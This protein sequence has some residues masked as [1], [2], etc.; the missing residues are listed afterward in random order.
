ME[1]DKE[2][3]SKNLTR[4]K[5]M[6]F[7]NDKVTI[8][9]PLYN[10][11]YTIEKCIN[12]IKQQSYQNLQVILVDDKSHDDSIQ[13]SLE[14]IANDERF[15]IIKQKHNKGVSAAR[16]RGLQ[17]GNGKF[18]FFLDAD[19]WLENDAIEHLVTLANQTDSDFVC[20]SHI[21]NFDSTEN[22]KEDG[23]PDIDSTFSHSELI[24][25]I[26]NHLKSPYKFTLLVHCWAKLYNLK[27]IKDNSIHFDEQLSQLE[28]V[29]FNYYY[30]AHCNHVSYKNEYIYHHR[31]DSNSHSLSTMTGKE[32][33]AMTN[34]LLAFSSIRSYLNLRDNDTQINIE[35]EV[36]HLFITTTIITLIRLCKSMIRSPSM[37]LYKNI[38][39]IS[40]SPEVIENLKFYSSGQ[41]ESRLIS[42]ALK[43]RTPFFV[44]ISGLI[45]AY[46]LLLTK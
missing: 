8:V 3:I 36:A 28:D 25:Y 26:K 2:V 41:G 33:N 44:L 15:I 46:T 13:K 45:R 34:N 7:H 32:A 12:S 29:N 22:K 39:L 20:A 21:Q 16:N 18:L 38:T 4:I 23:T 6:S 17:Y 9:V 40:K 31:I 19:D 43:T 1:L 14:I 11:T 24:S 30:L 35:K 10:C 27:I 37:A 42:I 5:P